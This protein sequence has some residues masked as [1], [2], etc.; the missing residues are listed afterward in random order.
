MSID[1]PHPPKDSLISFFIITYAITWGIGAIAIFFPIQF[2]ALFGEL[3]D[4]HLLYY[5]AVAAPTISSPIQTCR[6]A[7]FCV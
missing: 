1:S 4:N 7:G 3:S 2:Q 5:V 6:K